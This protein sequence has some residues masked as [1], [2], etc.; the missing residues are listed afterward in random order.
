MQLETKLEKKPFRQ[1]AFTP[2]MKPAIHVPEPPFLKLN[3]FLQQWVTKNPFLDKSMQLGKPDSPSEGSKRSEGNV[4]AR[5]VSLCEYLL[6]QLN[7]ASQNETQRR[8]KRLL[9]NKA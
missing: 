1:L 3:P 4:A 8:F 5:P 7:T 6:M 2:Q 9:L